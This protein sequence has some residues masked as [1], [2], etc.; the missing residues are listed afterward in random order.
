[1][2]KGA[3]DW[4]RVKGPGVYP[5][6]YAGWLVS[7]LRNL[8]SPA[9]RIVGRLGLRAESRVLEIGCGPGFFSPAI[10]R[11]LTS[12]HLTILDAQPGMLA[13]A[14]KRLQRRSLRNFTPVSGLAETLPFEAGQFDTVLMVTVL[15]ETTDRRQSV[16]EAAR[17]LKPGG[18]FSVTEAAG[19]PDHVRR[20]DLDRLALAAGMD[21]AAAWNGLLVKT[22]NY[23]RPA[24]PPA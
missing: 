19:D 23:R 22:F 12:G 5:V 15:G 8:I 9:S 21:R 13:L 6:A 24:G 4:E 14:T 20:A 7:P 1:M 2:S 11:K 10:A 18:V 17:V 16:L 3:T